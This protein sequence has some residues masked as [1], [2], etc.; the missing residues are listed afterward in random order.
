MCE[1]R[2]ANDP[3]VRRARID[4]GWILPRSY[5]LHIHDVT[6]HDSRKGAHDHDGDFSRNPIDRCPVVA[7]AYPRLDARASAHARARIAREVRRRM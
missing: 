2:L 7:I 1:S 4:G 5:C 6:D 3:L